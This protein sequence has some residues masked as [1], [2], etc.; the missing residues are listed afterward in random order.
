MILLP[1]ENIHPWQLLST[2]FQKNFQ[3]NYWFSGKLRTSHGVRRSIPIHE[4]EFIHAN[5]Q[6]IAIKYCGVHHTHIYKHHRDE[7]EL[8]IVDAIPNMHPQL[9]EAGSTENYCVLMLVEEYPHIKGMFE[10]TD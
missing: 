4:I 6:S 1:T 2:T 3:G 9:K 10:H 8:Y 5:I 7:Q